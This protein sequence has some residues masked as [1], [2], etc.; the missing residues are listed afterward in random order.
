[1]SPLPGHGILASQ[2]RKGAFPQGALLLAYQYITDDV[3]QL[4]SLQACSKK[5][6]APS[7]SQRRSVPI[8]LSLS[9]DK[10]PCRRSLRSFAH[11]TMTDA[12]LSRPL[13]SLVDDVQR[14]AKQAQFLVTVGKQEDALES[15]LKT[16]TLAIKLIPMHRDYHS[17]KSDR[18]QLGQKYN[19]LVKELSDNYE[20]Y[21]A[22]KKHKMVKQQQAGENKAA[23]DLKARMAKLRNNPVPVRIQDPRIRTQP[24]I[25]SPSGRSSKDGI[26]AGTEATTRAS[27]DAQSPTRKK[28]P[29][30][31]PKPPRLTTN[32]G[33]GMPKLP[34]AIYSPAR[35]GNTSHHQDL[36]S[37][38][39]RG[40]ISRA[41]S[42]FPV[43]R[44]TPKSTQSNGSSGPHLHVDI[45]LPEADIITVE[46]LLKY[47]RNE[48]CRILII[49]VRPR[50]DFEDGHIL[51]SST[52][53]IEPDILGRPGIEAQDV[54][55]SMVLGT[56][57]EKDH[58]ERRHEYDMIVIY[59]Q[60]SEDFG[61][62][63][64]NASK[65]FT[66]L[67]DFDYPDGH[68]ASK[69]PKLLKGGIV[70]WKDSMGSHALRNS[71]H[72]RRR[73]TYDKPWL[74]SPTKPI[75]N[76]EEAKRWEQHLTKPEDDEDDT[77]EESFEAAR[78]INDFLTRFPSVQESM[79]SPVETT[80]DRNDLRLPPR[81]IRPPASPLKSPN[82]PMPPQEPTRPP[83]A[84]PRRSYSGLQPPD[85]DEGTASKTVTRRDASSRGRAVGLQNPGN[86]CYANSTLQA[87]FASGDFGEELYT[88]AW[89]HLYK[90]PKKAD[91]KILPPQLLTKI[92]A[93]LFLWMGTAKFDMKADTLM[94][95]AAPL[96]SFSRSSAHKCL[97]CCR[98][99]LTCDLKVSAWPFIVT[100]T[101]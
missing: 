60:S 54:E 74:R 24:P 86:W 22:I 100:Q 90:P 47:Q 31:P 72:K 77:D 93:N 21:E 101:C 52:I 20:T 27:V 26:S 50:A 6:T 5:A 28:A 49:D 18:K 12:D 3:S 67:S 94:V 39:P 96:V 40:S 79:T 23:D 78:S 30:P 25:V 45:V 59:D 4:L 62:G 11:H 42:Y 14:G 53:C 82:L 55:D 83:P 16:S 43:I 36:P 70:A 58:F 29:P 99:R 10:E 17:L 57:E 73:S 76:V 69:H 44:S 92:M 75:Q 91:E 51:S 38:T 66:I 15:Y 98:W 34:D 9:A 19:H 84:V 68:P 41:T 64:N 65:L 32:G 13:A 85:D 2:N 1:M 35:G 87:L 81:P 71:G 63:K 88:N 7:V 89:Q 48:Q 97:Q 37:S 95:S 80:V 8:Y 56:A 33:V 61:D 46:E